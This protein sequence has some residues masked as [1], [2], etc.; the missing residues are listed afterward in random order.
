MPRTVLITGATG[1][2]GTALA[3][4]FAEAKCKLVLHGKGPCLFETTGTFVR[5]DLTDAKE[6]FRLALVAEEHG[7]DT[8]I[9]CMGIYAN[10]EIRMLQ[11]SSIQKI[12][13]T[14]LFAPIVLT[15]A[16]WPVLR[17]EKGIIAN[18]N[19]LAGKQCA[20]GESVYCASKFGLAGFMNS[21]QF[22]ATRDG[23]QIV[24]FYLGALQTRMTAGRKD[25]DKLIDVKEVADFIVRLC[26][27]LDYNSLLVTEVE[28][29]RRNY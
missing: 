17:R 28:V 12:L 3:Q 19:S 9:N 26:L 8:L 21:M 18:I 23:I 16:L 2:L 29:R 4:T 10:E 7:V 25:H 15:K 13:A 5:G 11:N 22:E 20:A 6:V 14:N 24:N 1:G 27:N